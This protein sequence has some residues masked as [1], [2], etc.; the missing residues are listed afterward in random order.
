MS[1]VSNEM[2]SRPIRI[3]VMVSG[4]GRGSNM[5]AIIDACQSGQIRGKVVVVI[6]TRRGAPAMERAAMAGV[7]TE[8]A[9]P[10]REGSDDGYAQ[11][12]LGIL[13]RH[14]VD[15]ICL[16][17]YMRLLPSEVV[18]RYRWRVMNI[19]P[20]LLPHFGGRGMYGHT[21]HE[22]VLRSGVSESGCTVHF[23]DEQYDHGPIIIQTRVPVLPGDTPETLAARVLPEEH[24]T[25]VRAVGLFAEGRLRV[26]DGV[27]T[28][29]D[30]AVE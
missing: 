27:V 8:V 29:V 15:L 28:V 21:V 7:A 12:L 3:A 11:R 1:S 30:R 26:Q 2:V 19:H 24:R 23:V 9:R 4:Q 20:G 5:Q 17:G 13:Q 14:E 10:P 18:E 25:Y 6:G 16:A 22:A